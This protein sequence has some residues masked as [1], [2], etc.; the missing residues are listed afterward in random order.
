MAVKIEMLDGM[1]VREWL[2]RDEQLAPG[3]ELFRSDRE[4]Q[5]M[6]Y[7]ISHSQLLLRS[8]DGRDRQGRQHDTT[9]E[10]LFKPVTTV[11]IRDGYEGL[12][13]RCATLEEAER[14]RA[15]TPSIDF[16]ADDRFFV[17]ET[18]GEIDYVVAMAVGWREDILSRTRLSF[19]AE[20]DP[21]EP[22]WP[23]T[24]LDG[25]D[26]GFTVASPQDLID[27]LAADPGVEQ[28]REKWR[29][30]YVVMKKMTYPRGETEISGAG[31]FVSRADAEDYRTR[32]QDKVTDCWIEQLPIAI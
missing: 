24:M 23:R 25:F 13:I 22:V 12:V 7:T 27:A 6:A 21:Y 15:A 32:I 2:N 30:V 26:M 8:R 17:L 18:V 11:K 16:F 5:L 4:F 31:V 20:N 19:Y 28:R 14:I 9:V 1:A 3:S 10:V 29:A